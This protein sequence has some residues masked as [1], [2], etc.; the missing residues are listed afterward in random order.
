MNSTI[1][2]KFQI[3]GGVITLMVIVSLV[4]MYFVNRTEDTLP[5]A[6][7]ATT[8]PLVAT[9]TKEVFPPFELGF[10][11]IEVTVYAEDLVDIDYMTT[12]L[13]GQLLITSSKQGVIRVLS[14]KDG[15]GISD[16]RKLLLGNLKNPYGTAI[17]CISERR[18][19][20]YVAGEDKLVRYAYNADEIVG[21][22]GE[23]LRDFPDSKEHPLHALKI[24]EDLEGNKKIVIG[25]GSTCDVC[26]ESDPVFATLITTDMNGINSAEYAR[27]VRYVSDIAVDINGVIWAT[28]LGR[29]DLK[30]RESHDE[31]NIIKEDLFYGWPICYGD[32]VHDFEFD[33]ATYVREPCSAPI[34]EP[35]YITL[36]SD[37]NP[38]DIAFFPDRGWPLE[39]RG[40][41]LVAYGGGGDS[42]V[43]ATIAR[44]DS[45]S[46]SSTMVKTF[47]TH[48]VNKAGISNGKPS[49]MHF[50]ADGGLYVSD[51]DNG[52][53][54]KLTYIGD[55]NNLSIDIDGDNEQDGIDGCFVSG[56]NNELCGED[57][58]DS[59]CIYL[60]ELSCFEFATCERQLS[61]SCAWSHSE[62][63]QQ[64]IETIEK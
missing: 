36:S 28:D 56:C 15:D 16:E 23:E 25:I 2:N 34:E 47:M 59:V 39:L 24:V 33:T 44:Y 62:K 42:G 30:E 11:D 22:L 46:A 32:N 6:T 12:D 45:P 38:T 52:I 5:V 51:I 64:C 49:A 63:F 37:S 54:Y 57:K 20:L 17:D 3:I 48:W 26:N 9:T 41:L 55:D 58:L 10:D 31:I 7:M 27:G 35:S 4:I 53:I 1:H 60:P 18:C 8:T 29:T 43:E 13:K 40:D 14:D 50:D 19:W 21:L 61:G